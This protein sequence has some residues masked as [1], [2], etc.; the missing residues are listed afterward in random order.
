MRI[1]GQVDCCENKT[2]DLPGNNS[3]IQLLW[4]RGKLIPKITLLLLL[5]SSIINIIDPYSGANLHS[6]CAHSF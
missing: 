2:C 6:S 5:V 4:L 1:Y 3:R